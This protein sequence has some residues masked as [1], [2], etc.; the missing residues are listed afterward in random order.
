MKTLWKSTA[1][2]AALALAAAGAAFAAPPGDDDDKTPP[3]GK[4]KA[5]MHH[6]MG[7]R[8]ALAVSMRLGEAMKLDEAGTIRLYQAIKK[9]QE[10]QKAAREKMK[11]THQALADALEKDEKN[12]AKLK[13]LT[14]KV[15]EQRSAMAKQHEKLVDELRAQFS[16]V[17]Q[18]RLVVALPKIHREIRQMMR[19]AVQGHAMQ[20]R[21]KIQRGDGG[22]EIEIHEGPG[23]PMGMRGGLPPTP[24]SP[25]DAPIPPMM[26]D[27]DEDPLMAFADDVE[28]EVMVE[29]EIVIE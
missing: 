5:K 22:D 24:P 25:P 4:G 1:L 17:Q 21:M 3:P 19:M 7:G 28:D 29:K 14:A 23:H 15:L 2:P 26:G 20:R 12:E 9:N 13:E 11:E 18:A 8:M 27:D 6:E 16:T 10:G